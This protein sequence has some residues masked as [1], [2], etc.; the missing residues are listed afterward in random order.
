MKLKVYQQGGGLIY[1]P[2]IP[3]QYAVS[4]SNS[5][6]RSNSSDEDSKIDPL[7]K[8]LISLMKGQNLL[9]SDIEVIYDRLIRFQKSTQNLSDPLG[10]GT[11]SSDYRSV[12]PGMLQIMRLVETAKNNKAE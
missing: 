11:G 2:F 5:S 9:S 7:D 8:E 1:T 10:L 12:M 3:E 6:K 4:G